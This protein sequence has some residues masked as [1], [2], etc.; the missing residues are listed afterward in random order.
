MITVPKLNRAHPMHPLVEDENGDTYFVGNLEAGK[1]LVS[2]DQ[3]VFV[4]TEGGYVLVTLNDSDDV[5]DVAEWGTGPT[6]EV[7]WRYA[8]GAACG[9]IDAEYDERGLITILQV[10]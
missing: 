5:N 10:V 1:R 2:R 6:E 4:K 9:P 8:I 7:A 3:V